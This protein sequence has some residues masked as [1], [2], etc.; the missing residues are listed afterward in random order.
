MVIWF[1][2]ISDGGFFL[3]LFWF[4]DG[5]DTGGRHILEREGEQSA[6]VQ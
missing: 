2:I 1:V 6:Y 4:L 3:M 5:W